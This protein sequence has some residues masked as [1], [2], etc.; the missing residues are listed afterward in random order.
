MPISQ[1]EFENLLA[2]ETKEIPQDLVWEENA[3]RSP[4]REFRVAV[5][6]VA[7]YPLFVVGRY[8]F[9]AGTLSY[10]LIHKSTGRIYALD[11]GADHHN[12]DCNNTG[13][14][15]KHRWSEGFRDKH[16][17]V[18]EDITA[19][20]DNPIEVWGQFCKEA[21]IRHTGQMHPP[22]VQEEMWL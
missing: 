6:S 1:Q 8:N 17:Y 10:A 3:D 14:K 12:P 7:G 22:E 15:H 2:D 4:V 13:E 20:W 18:P 19:P 5:E 11:L 16:A 9:L 21:G